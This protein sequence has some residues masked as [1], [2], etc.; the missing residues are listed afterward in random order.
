MTKERKP[1]PPPPTTTTKSEIKIVK[2]YKGNSNQ[3]AGSQNHCC[4]CCWWWWWCGGGGF[5]TTNGW[6][7]QK[8]YLVVGVWVL[9]YFSCFVFFVDGEL[10]SGAEVER[11]FGQSH[12][13]VAVRLS[14]LKLI[15]R[16]QFRSNQI[17]STQKTM[18]QKTHFGQFSR[19]VAKWWGGGQVHTACV[20]GSIL[21]RWCR[22]W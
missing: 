9:V 15:R 10:V 22:L 5:Q 14:F 12:E 2:D 16:N 11:S 13:R 3:S 17:H 18:C 6:F 1:P 21:P 20:C 19:V 4:C 8:L 7:V